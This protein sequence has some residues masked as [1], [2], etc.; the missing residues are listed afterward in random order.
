MP[1]AWYHQAGAAA[2]NEPP[3]SGSSPAVSSASRG[4]AG[5]QRSGSL[6]VPATRT[7]PRRSESLHHRVSDDAHELESPGGMKPRNGF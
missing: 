7:T 1:T 4:G 6:R 2:A 3:R 5:T